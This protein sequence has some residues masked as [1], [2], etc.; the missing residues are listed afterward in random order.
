MD[1]ITELSSYGITLSTG[2]QPGE[3]EIILDGVK[4]VALA[5][6]TLSKDKGNP[7]VST[8]DIFQRVVGGPLTFRRVTGR[9][10]CETFNGDRVIECGNVAGFKKQ[11]IVHELGHVIDNNSFLPTTNGRGALYRAVESTATGNCTSS[12]LSQFDLINGTPVPMTTNFSSNCFVV[13]D[14]KVNASGG[15]IMGRNAALV[16]SRGDR[17]WGTGPSNVITD[18]QQHPPY[19]DPLYNACDNLTNLTTEQKDRCKQ[20]PIEEAVAD[21]FLNWVYRTLDAPTP[22]K[23]SVPGAWDGFHNTSW[24]TTTPSCVNTAGCDDYNF[25]GDARFDWMGFL[26]QTISLQKVW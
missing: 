2:W 22:L 24:I 26:L 12:P 1:T 15:R 17:G 7:T 6:R 4:D 21:M 18:F 14:A 13:N 16:W 23:T 10:D 25:P 11:T 3:P 19:L 9:I 5:L 20:R 8:K